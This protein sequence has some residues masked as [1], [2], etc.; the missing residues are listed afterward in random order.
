MHIRSLCTAIQRLWMAISNLQT[1]ISAVLNE[2]WRQERSKRHAASLALFVCRIAAAN[3]LSFAPQL[4]ENEE[5]GDKGRRRRV[6]R[7]RE[8]GCFGLGE[9]LF[10]GGGK[11]GAEGLWKLFLG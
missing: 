5:E 4:F 2:N 8:A 10:L 3:G 11:R 9:S 6:V 7:G 1:E